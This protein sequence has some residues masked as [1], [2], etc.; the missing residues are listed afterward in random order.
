MRRVLLALA[1]MG[2]VTGAAYAQDL[3]GGVFIAHHPAGLTFTTDTPAGGWCAQCTL[4]SCDAQNNDNL[5]LDGT[6]LVWYVVAAFLTN[7]TWCGV[8]FGL[9]YPMDDITVAQKGF[10][11]PSAALEIQGTGW[12]ESGTGTSVVTT[13]IPWSGNFK[14]VYWFSA[15]S[16]T[17]V[18]AL[19]QIGDNLGTP[20]PTAF[21]NCSQQEFPA[22]AYGAIGFGMPGIDACP[23]L[24]PPDQWACCL[25]DGTCIL[26]ETADLCMAAGGEWFQ[27]LL[28]EAVVCPAPVVCCVDH[29]CYFVHEDECTALGGV[30]HPEFVDCVNEPC[31]QLTPAD[32]T[33]WGTIKAIYR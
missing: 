19:L 7:Q 15:Y 8:E 17:G 31:Q 22:D 21:A 18:P 26:T 3:T 25:Y 27:G 11:V 1:I 29:V 24:P 23:E 28:C 32:P 5:A 13:D 14:P 33:N 20:G 6:N 30:L 10:C 4:T 9:Q 2:L 16:Y 12:P